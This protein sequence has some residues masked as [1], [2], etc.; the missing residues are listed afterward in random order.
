MLTY[1]QWLGKAEAKRQA[2]F[3]RKKKG[4]GAGAL[5]NDVKVHYTVL[6]R[7]CIYV[8]LWNFWRWNF[9]TAQ[10]CAYEVLVMAHISQHKAEQ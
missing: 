9:V 7:K 6:C 8:H 3:V 1:E 2:H 10:W 4:H 5:S